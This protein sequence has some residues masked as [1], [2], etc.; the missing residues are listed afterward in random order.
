MPLGIGDL[1]RETRPLAL[2]QLGVPK[3]CSIKTAA[4][5]CPL[6][7]T[8]TVFSKMFSGAS[9]QECHDTGY[10]YSN[11]SAYSWVVGFNMFSVPDCGNGSY[12]NIGYGSFY[13][14]GAWR[15]T[16]LTSP[17]LYMN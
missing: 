8:S 3:C 6:N 5:L 10:V 14:S 16:S 1:D 2:S 4:S 11:V 9:W 13:Q 15:G 17:S 12:R 7:L